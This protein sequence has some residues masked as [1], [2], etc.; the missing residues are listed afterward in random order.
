MK[1]VTG[2]LNRQRSAPKQQ[3]E[4]AKIQV[5]LNVAV[6]KPTSEFKKVEGV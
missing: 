2:V 1:L 4:V 6:S 3:D 5:K